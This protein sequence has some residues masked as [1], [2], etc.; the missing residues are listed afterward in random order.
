MEGGFMVFYGRN[1]KGVVKRVRKYL[2]WKLKG[3]LVK[4]MIDE[5]VSLEV[6]VLGLMFKEKKG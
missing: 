5:L 1:L 2:G 6:K 3:V 4:D